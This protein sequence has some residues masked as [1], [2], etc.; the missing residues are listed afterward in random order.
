MKGW[1]DFIVIHKGL[2]K[3]LIWFIETLKKKTWYRIMTI[4]PYQICS[5]ANTRHSCFFYYKNYLSLNIFLL[6]FFKCEEKI[7]ILQNKIY[8]T[9]TINS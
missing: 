9:I 5:N 1:H 8:M 6:Q 7:I 4:K 3:S 2:K